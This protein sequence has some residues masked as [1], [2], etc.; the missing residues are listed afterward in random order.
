MPDPAKP[1]V[2]IV[3]DEGLAPPD[4]HFDPLDA[5]SAAGMFLPRLNNIVTLTMGSLSYIDAERRIQSLQFQFNPIELER[6]RTIKFTRT[7]TGNTLE[8]LRAGLRNLPKRKF[9]RKPDPWDMTLSLRY[10]ASYTA[11]G[12]E[13]PALQAYSHRIDRIAKAI[14]FFEALVEPV[15]FVSENQK[16]ANADETPPPPLLVF[17][18]GKRSWQCALKHLR[19]K[20]DDY[21]PDLYPRRFEATL[22]L[23]IV[24]TVQQNE[25]GKKGGVR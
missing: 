3:M 22:T 13:G 25:Q 9:T 15:P 1:D 6:S 12:D 19:I 20:E 8:E 2:L 4:Q 17:Q 7:P 10:D 5:P 24:E 18:Y 11:N 14:Q 21:T 23:E 16:T